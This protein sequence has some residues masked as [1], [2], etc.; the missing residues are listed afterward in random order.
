MRVAAVLTR[1]RLERRRVSVD[2]Q[3]VWLYRRARPT[4]AD[5]EVVS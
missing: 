5:L 1:A 3:R 2:G 4:S